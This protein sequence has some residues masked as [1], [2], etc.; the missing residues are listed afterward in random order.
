LP[1]LGPRH[2]QL[3]RSPITNATGSIVGLQGMLWDITDRVQL[4]A[5]LR[6]AQKMETVGQLAGGVAHDF[7]NL[8][9][10]IQGHAS[11][12][13]AADRA[14]PTEIA[15]LRQIVAAAERAA[16]LTR[17]LLAFS[18]KQ[19]LQPVLLDVNQLVQ[20]LTDLLR[21]TVG[22]NIL[23]HFEP[24]P[25]L[26]PIQ[27]DPVM[28]EQVLLNLAV[29]S[30]DAMPKGGR[31]DIR[32]QLAQIDETLANSQPEA[33]PGRYVQIVVSDTGTGIDP[34][35]LAHIFEPFFTTKEVGKGT[36]LGLATVYGIVKQ[37]HGWITVASEPGQGTRFQIHLPAAVGSP[38]PAPA[39]AAPA[40]P[41]RGGPETILVV[42]D[43]PALRTLVRH[44]LEFSG[45]TVLEAATGRAALSI[46]REHRARIDLL[47]TD[48]IM[49]DGING[50]E[51]ALQLQ[52]D[53]P[54]LRVLYTSGYG[55]DIVGVNFVLQEGV[56]F[57]QK[58]FNPRVLAEAVR[59]CLDH[60]LPTAPS[61][62][63]PQK[64]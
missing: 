44:I 21:R 51:L 33:S 4:E 1:D 3:I 41:T 54:A 36:G 60:P 6:Q 20:Q 10:V 46:W 57:L 13:L 26:P 59:S 14:K 55:T 5:H 29:N 25:D 11:I 12:L 58:P 43:E 8:L 28:I 53:R 50:R 24:H 9:T 61:T 17:Q 56:N 39:P 30:R 52:A 22:E 40:P 48:M 27:A 47:L 2:L 16:Y 7:N 62:P 23:V 38:G 35:H 42:E 19:M 15:S 63:M 34:E 31:L 49:P 45:Y 37:H 64:D 18:R 32:T